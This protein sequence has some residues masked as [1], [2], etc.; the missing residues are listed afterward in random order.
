MLKEY[1]RS[2]YIANDKPLLT[3][4]DFIGSNVSEQERQVLVDFIS[5]HVVSS[6]KYR[7]IDRMQRDAILKEIEFSYSGCTDESCQLVL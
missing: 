1:L 3:V 4:L 7:V 2:A 5:S 6:G